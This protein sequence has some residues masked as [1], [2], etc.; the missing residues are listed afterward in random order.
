MLRILCFP[1]RLLAL[2]TSTATN[3]ALP[4]YCGASFVM[5]GTTI[6]HGPHQAA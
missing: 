1:A 4:V 2:S 3:A 6:L 5:V